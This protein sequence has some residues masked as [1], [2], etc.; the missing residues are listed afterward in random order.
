MKYLYT[1][2]AV[3]IAF[4][5]QMEA[6]I[7]RRAAIDIGSGGTKVAIADVDTES[8]Q[9]VEILLDKSFS[10]PYQASLDNFS[11]VPSMPK[12]KLLV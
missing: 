6:A 12:H 10:V 11:T 5:C 2:I 9:I 7:E 4:S 3:I 8:N 1:L